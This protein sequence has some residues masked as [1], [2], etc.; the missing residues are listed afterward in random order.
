MLL[1][2]FRLYMIDAK[3]PRIVQ[4]NNFGHIN[5]REMTFV[6]NANDFTIVPNYISV[7]ISSKCSKYGRIMMMCATFCMMVSMKQ[8][9]WLG[10]KRCREEHVGD[11]KHRFALWEPRNT[12]IEKQIPEKCMKYYSY[13]ESPSTSSFFPDHAFVPP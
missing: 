10:A 4:K 5:R 3:V 8:A 12:L 11:E 6:V 2:G 7:A 9:L 1:A 13:P